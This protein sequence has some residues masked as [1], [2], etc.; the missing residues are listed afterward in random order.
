MSYYRGS[1]EA[2]TA[3]LILLLLLLQFLLAIIPAKI[4]KTKGYGFAGYYIFGFFIF[5]FALTVALLLPDK[6]NMLKVQRYDEYPKKRES[7]Y[8]RNL[9]TNIPLRPC[10]A[11]IYMFD[12]DKINHSIYVKMYEELDIDSIRATVQGFDVYENLLY[13]TSLTATNLEK[14][15]NGFRFI[16]I[17]DSDNIQLDAVNYLEVYIEAYAL[18]SNAVIFRDLL[19]CSYIIP[20]G[21]LT[22]FKRKY[23]ED[24]VSPLEKYEEFWVCVCG[25]KCE[26]NSPCPECKR[27][28]GEVDYLHA[29][30]D[31]LEQ[32]SDIPEIM[33]RFIYLKGIL[34]DDKFDKAISYL[35][36]I[37]S[38]AYYYTGK[39]GEN[40]K[41]NLKK[42]LEE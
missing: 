34:P 26:N 25:R 30:F 19:K 18:G 39:V 29:F 20:V 24:A 1:M 22:D 31:A 23:G 37:R 21:E 38:G 32:L 16:T 36:E 17:I 33:N 10:N 28:F 5:P 8:I 14:S 2:T 41:N 7:V 13:E 42:L 6:A 9:Y 40:E 4:A 3:F 15:E 11:K 27:T 12:S 35:K